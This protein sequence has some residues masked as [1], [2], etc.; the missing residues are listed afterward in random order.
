MA[1]P[2]LT[3][4]EGFKRTKIINIDKKVS[5]PIGGEIR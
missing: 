4:R 2:T 3:G 1:P 5:P